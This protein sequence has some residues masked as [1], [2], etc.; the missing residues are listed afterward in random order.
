MTKSILDLLEKTPGIVQTLHGIQYKRIDITDYPHLLRM[1]PI[2]SPPAQ[3]DWVQ[4][5]RGHYKGDVGKVAA[6]HTWGVEL[7]LVPRI[8]TQRPENPRK[9]KATSVVPD[10]KL[11]YPQDFP[12]DTSNLL[13]THG[14]DNL[15]LSHGLLRKDYDYQSISQRVNK[16][17]WKHY[18][19]FLSSN[20]P[21]I[22][23]SD[24]PRPQEWTFNDGDEVIVSS[25]DEKGVLDTIEPDYAVVEFPAHGLQRVPWHAIRK[26]FKIGDFVSI[27]S[28][29]HHGT[30]G[31]VIHIEENK[32]VIA[33][34]KTQIGAN[35]TEAIQVRYWINLYYSM[36][37]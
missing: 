7:Y 28:G 17:P 36:T 33:D 16:M 12:N 23:I 26:S 34:K 6:I 20:H 1:T 11:L 37:I 5:K 27:S 25:F 35:F 29:P 2:K 24:I 4:V 22:S 31:W 14:S 13:A 15:I 21:E 3:G 30:N 32:V 19:M 18:T 10:A 9:R 8:N